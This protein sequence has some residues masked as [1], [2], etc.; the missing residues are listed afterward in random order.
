ML[1]AVVVASFALLVSGCGGAADGDTPATHTTLADL[2]A[3][4]IEAGLECENF[5]EWTDTALAGEEGVATGT[6]NPGTGNVSAL[7]IYPTSQAAEAAA[8]DDEPSG[9]LR[10]PRLLGPNWVISSDQADSL[11]ALAGEVLPADEGYGEQKECVEAVMDIVTAMMSDQV[12][13]TSDAYQQAMFTYGSNSEVFIIATRRV[14]VLALQ[15]MVMGGI[16]SALLV[17]RTEAWTQC[18]APES[19]Y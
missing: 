9:M 15:E 2:Q 17:A 3:Q 11:D 8:N 4:A 10:G 1:V 7:A 13:E 16:D 5:T 6:C 12:G 19:G 14:A 18:A